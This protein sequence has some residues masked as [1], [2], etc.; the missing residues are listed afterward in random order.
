MRVVIIR[1]TSFTVCDEGNELEIE[2]DAYQPIFLSS[3]DKEALLELLR[4]PTG[5]FHANCAS[6]NGDFAHF[7]KR[8]QTM[9]MTVYVSDVEF[10]EHLYSTEVAALVD[11][12][13]SASDV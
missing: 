3:R 1:G 4:E 13:V 8:G 10:K 6:G 5:S 9:T 12:L 7:E 2:G 11:L